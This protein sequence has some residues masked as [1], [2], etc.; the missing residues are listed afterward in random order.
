LS[1]RTPA[2]AAAIAA[3]AVAISCRPCAAA[4]IAASTVAGGCRRSGVGDICL[5]PTLLS[6]QTLLLLLLWLLLFM[7]PR[8]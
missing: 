5:W 3:S 4:A 7:A 8:L 6:L 2:T 1:S